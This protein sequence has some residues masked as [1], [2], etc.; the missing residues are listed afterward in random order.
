MENLNLCI[1]TFYY[2]N[3]NTVYDLK[4]ITA[5]LCYFKITICLPHRRPKNPPA[6]PPPPKNGINWPKLKDP[7]GIFPEEE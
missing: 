7:G 5:G 3:E 4:Y 2:F 1:E 6:N